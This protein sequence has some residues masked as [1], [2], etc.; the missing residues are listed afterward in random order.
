MAREASGL[1]TR[2][3]S[4]RVRGTAY[5]RGVQYGG[6]A[7]DRIHASVRLYAEVFGALLDVDWHWVRARARSFSDDITAFS[8]DIAQEL[9]GIADGAQLEYEDVLALNCRTELIDAA[10]VE[11]ATGKRSLFGSECSAFVAEGQSTASGS[12]IVGQNW[13]WIVGSEGN[14]VVLVVEQDDKPNY[15]TVV[16]A[17][18]LAKMGMN[19]AGVALT[20]NG[21]VSERDIGGAGLPFHVILRALIETPT[22]SEGVATLQRMTR[23]T[24]G[25]YLLASASGVAVNVETTPGG[26]RDVVVD[27]PHEGVLAHTNHFVYQSHVDCKVAV[28]EAPS[29]PMRLH[30]LRAF[31]QQHNGQLDREQMQ[32]I[33]ADHAD[34]PWGLCSHE[35]LDLP[36]H[37][38]YATRASLIMDPAAKAMWLAEGNPCVAPF[39]ELDTAVLGA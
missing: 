19:E 33:L 30:R 10:N 34:H 1:V 2:Y 18:I 22:V 5:E 23:A 4:I 12:L 8:D 35:N 16:E 36:P 3:P 28:W 6:L 29:S 32:T 21:L 14:V 13:D 7:S 15:V 11:T 31:L 17:G 9:R 38:R 25:N 26:Y 20:T 39:R 37:E 24:S 27:P